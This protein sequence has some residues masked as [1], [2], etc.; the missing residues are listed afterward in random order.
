M[1]ICK[2]QKTLPGLLQIILEKFDLLWV[3]GARAPVEFRPKNI[4]SSWHAKV[5]ARYTKHYT[6]QI[7]WKNHG[8]L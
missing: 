8:M 5:L 1:D 2:I 3:E 4:E 7:P 6:K